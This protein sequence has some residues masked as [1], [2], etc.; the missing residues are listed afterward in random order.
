MKV[1]TR[2]QN[3]TYIQTQLE[4]ALAGGNVS[5]VNIN[6]YLSKYFNKCLFSSHTWLCPTGC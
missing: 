1:M 2:L 5:Q 6:K 3:I 4:R